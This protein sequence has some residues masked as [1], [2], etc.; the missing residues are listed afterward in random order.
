MDQYDTFGVEE[1]RDGFFDATFYRSSTQQGQEEDADEEEDQGLSV[2]LK[3]DFE[4]MVRM[5]LVDSKF[6]FTATFGTRDGIL[7]VKAFLAYFISYILC[8]IPQTQDF[9]GR[10]SYWI[11]IAALFNHPGRTVGA[12]IDGTFGCILGAAIGLGVGSL[13]LQVASST[14]AS[15]E[16][17][18]GIIAIFLVPMIIIFSWVRCSLLRLYQ[19]C[20]SA[21]L[22][23]LFLCMVETAEI[24]HIKTWERRRVWEFAIPWMVGLGICLVV[25]VCLYPETGERAVAYASLIYVFSRPSST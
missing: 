17:Y 8:L 14:S 18:G 13:A 23:M 24:R 3:R 19:T 4:D 20:L 11:T 10:Y 15:N 5:Q 6:F 1:L 12:Q 9:L 2:S 25:N 16:G 21:G 7:L 22:S